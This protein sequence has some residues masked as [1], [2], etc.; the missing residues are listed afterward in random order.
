MI[1]ALENGKL[2]DLSSLQH[3]L[4]AALI[5]KAAIVSQPYQLWPGDPK[6][7]PL[8]EHLLWAAVII[9]DRENFTMAVDLMVLEKMES[10]HRGD[11]PDTGMVDRLIDEQLERLLQFVNSRDLKEKITANIKSLRER[12]G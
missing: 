8:S 1:T 11:F 3:R 4:R 9:R 10:S 2:P 5:K 6:I 12:E 7:N